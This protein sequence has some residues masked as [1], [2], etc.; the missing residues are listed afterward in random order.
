MSII[1]K[2]IRLFFG[3]DFLE[4]LHIIKNS[5]IQ[6][7]NRFLFFIKRKYKKFFCHTLSNTTAISIGMLAI[8]KKVYV[9]LAIQSINSLHYQNPKAEVL[10]HLDSFCYSYFLKKQKRLD[11]P[12]QV[13]ASL[14]ED[15]TNEPWQFTKLKV[16]LNLS[17]KNIPFVDADSFWHDDISKHLSEI[18]TFLVIVNKF[19]EVEKEKE[20]IQVLS[21]EEK[22]LEFYHFNVGFVYIPAKYF[23]PDFHN[24]CYKLINNIKKLFTENKIDGKTFRLCEEI[25]LSIAAQVFFESIT[26]LKETDGPGNTHIIESFYYGCTHGV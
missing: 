20:L 9:D 14:I 3:K 4:K 7:Y 8:R 16:I 10:L 18:P 21:Q 12:K 26:T 24:F 15:N 2:I 13:R 6:S 17:Q 22:W 1:K 5:I 19:K 23:S 11:Y 25:T